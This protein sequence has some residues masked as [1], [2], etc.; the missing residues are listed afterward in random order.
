[1]TAR[2][3]QLLFASLLVAGCSSAN[4]NASDG[5][6]TPDASATPDAGADS[7]S[8]DGGHDASSTSD[9]SADATATDAGADSGSTCV[10]PTITSCSAG[11]PV[12]LAAGGG[13]V[14][15]MF[16][17]G[18]YVLSDSTRIARVST[19]GAVITPWTTVPFSNSP[20][21]H[22]NGIQLGANGMGI[23]AATRTS[24]FG[25]NVM[26]A[27]T[28]VVD[29]S[30]NAVVGPFTIASYAEYIAITRDA[31][32]FAF[33][34]GSNGDGEFTP[35]QS[36]ASP[37]NSGVFLSSPSGYPIPAVASGPNN[38]LAGVWFAGDACELVGAYDSS[39]SYLNIVTQSLIP[40]DQQP[41]CALTAEIS[42]AHAQGH[43]LVSYTRFQPTA[44]FGFTVYDDKTFAANAWAT[45]APGAYGSNVA[46]DGCLFGIAWTVNTSPNSV[47]L[48]AS[49]QLVD[50]SGNPL[51]PMVPLGGATTG[52]PLVVV[53][54]PTGFVVVWQPLSSSNIVATPITCQ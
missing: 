3:S 6:A 21:K 25:S 53:P 54:T 51:A 18:A 46:S 39:G 32:G 17:N 43:Y 24:S 30:V 27:E 7:S 5:G 2:R 35:L 49:F 50:A 47:V 14:D 36:N 40:W 11:T 48:D 19:S 52:E 9:A 16:W 1:M 10:T 29:G 33:G 42:M 44:R 15:A 13:L 41:D 28:M 45:P 20:L 31:T 34:N 37:V 8:I 12:T 4:N 38:F 22:A 23:V 26:D